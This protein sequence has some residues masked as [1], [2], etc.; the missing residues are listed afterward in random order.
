MKLHAK[1]LMVGDFVFAGLKKFDIDNKII[2]YPSKVLSLSIDDSIV[3]EGENKKPWIRLM[4]NISPIPLTAE[5]LEKNF[6][7]TEILVWYGSED[8]WH[9][10]C[11]AFEDL[12]V[13]IEIECVHQLQH[14]LRLCG[15]EKEI[16]L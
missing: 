16:Q 7:D 11:P 3:V 4:Y 10:E 5:I 15:F 13:E 12:Q 6:P 2:P 14:I 8:K 9:I 1:D